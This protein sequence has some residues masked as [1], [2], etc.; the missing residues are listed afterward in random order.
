MIYIALSEPCMSPVIELTLSQIAGDT[1]KNSLLD[2]LVDYVFSNFIRRGL[3][4]FSVLHVTW[5]VL[6]GVKFPKLQFSLQ[7][8]I[9]LL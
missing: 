1:I 4:Y 5:E 3:A 2:H 7:T 8:D 9:Q 6:L